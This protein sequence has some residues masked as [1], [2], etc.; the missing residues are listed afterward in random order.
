MKLIRRQRNAYALLFIISIC[1]T[2]WFGAAFMVK[3]AFVFGIIS[4]ASLL[5]LVRQEGFYNDRSI[6]FT[7]S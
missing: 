4:V 1:L 2:V 7:K 6:T 3:T 5:F